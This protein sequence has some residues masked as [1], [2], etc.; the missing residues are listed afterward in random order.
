VD[1]GESYSN[2]ARKLGVDEETVRIRV[3]RVRERGFIPAWRIMVN[4]LLIN[5]HE[6]HLE[7]EVRDEERKADAISKIRTVDGVNGIV[8]FRGK[9]IV[10]LMY[11]EDHD[12]LA[13]KVRQI[14]SICGSQRLALWRGHSLVLTCR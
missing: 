13:R 5:C 8:D 9:E 1:R 14:E 12:S 2:I 3:K 10:V 11:Y 4:P 6:A 7:I